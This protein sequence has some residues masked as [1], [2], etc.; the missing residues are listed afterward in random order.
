MP[1]VTLDVP[2]AMVAMLK[3]LESRMRE[4]ET[5]KTGAAKAVTEA[6]VDAVTSK[7]GLEYKRRSL[8][9]LDI[10]SRGILVD[11][12]P[13]ARV[14]R[15]EATYFAKEG[16]VTVTRSLY[17]ERGVRNA[18]TVDTVGLRSGAA[19]YWLPDAAVS[20]VDPIG[21]TVFPGFSGDN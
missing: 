17:R 18:K 12:K 15:Y 7:L 3:A 4:V 9:A 1:K 20:E 13:H 10:D 16:P 14:G 8:Q 5:D 11:G 21:W 6:E 2:E 19:G